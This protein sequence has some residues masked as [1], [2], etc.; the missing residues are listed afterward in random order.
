MYEAELASFSQRKLEFV[1]VVI[2][3]G[4]LGILDFQSR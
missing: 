2:L 3:G 4:R 1:I